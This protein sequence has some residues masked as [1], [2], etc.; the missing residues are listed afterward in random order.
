MPDAKQLLYQTE[1]KQPSQVFYEKAV[2]TL[3]YRINVHVRFLLGTIQLIFV[4]QFTT[5]YV[6]SALYDY[7][8][9]IF[10]PSIFTFSKK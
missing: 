1:K 10:S 6:Y 5:L 9:Q 3:G 4:D 8:F 7:Y 2:L